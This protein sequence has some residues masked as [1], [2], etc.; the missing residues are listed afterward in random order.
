MPAP[1]ALV[2]AALGGLVTAGVLLVG[3]LSLVGGTTEPG[4]LGVAGAVVILPA[5]LVALAA[6]F[7][8]G[9]RLWATLRP[10]TDTEQGN[11]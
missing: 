5:G 7:Y 6:G 2:A 8:A 11:P 9:R 3:L 10:A 4:M 1:I